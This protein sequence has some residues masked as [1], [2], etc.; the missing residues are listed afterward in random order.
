MKIHKI[1]T[2]PGM[3]LF[4]LFL[5]SGAVILFVTEKGLGYLAE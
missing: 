1:Y 3:I 5:I 4:Y 2:Y